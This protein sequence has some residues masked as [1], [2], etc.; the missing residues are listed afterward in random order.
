MWCEVFLSMDEKIWRD[1]RKEVDGQELPLRLL[2]HGG[3]KFVLVFCPSYRPESIL[4]RK[5]IELKLS[6]RPERSKASA[7]KGYPLF[8]LPDLS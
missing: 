1:L 4:S 8:E 6:S 2:Q 7:V 5:L 3:K